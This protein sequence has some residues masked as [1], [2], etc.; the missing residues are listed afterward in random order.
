MTEESITCPQCGMTSYNETDVAERYCGNC[1]NWHDQLDPRPP[2]G[3]EVYTP[4]KWIAVQQARE[5]AADIEVLRRAAKILRPTHP[6]T[7]LH[8]EAIGVRKEQDLLRAA[9]P[10]EGAP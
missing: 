8:L 1:R 3:A 9:T 4:P 5:A 2:S 10:T 7:A 6:E